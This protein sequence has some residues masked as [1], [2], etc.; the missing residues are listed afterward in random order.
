[1]DSKAKL[2]E[3]ELPAAHP[4]TTKVLVFIDHDNKVIYLWRG[5][6]ADV[7]KKLVGTRVVARFSH[8]YPDYRIRPVGEG[9]EPAALRDLLSRE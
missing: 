6:K 7:V 2:I 5:K 8:T 9:N 3:S 1:M 4:D